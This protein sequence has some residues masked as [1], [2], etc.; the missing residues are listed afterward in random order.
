[1][2][3]DLVAHLQRALDFQLHAGTRQIE[4]QCGNFLSAMLQG[5][6]CFQSHANV[7]AFLTVIVITLAHGRYPLCCRVLLWPL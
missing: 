5:D 6:R 1:M 2:H 7:I 3:L 4:A